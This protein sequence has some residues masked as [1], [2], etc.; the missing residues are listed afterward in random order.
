MQPPVPGAILNRKR[1]MRC[2]EVAL[3]LAFRSKA[4]DRG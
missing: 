3:P 2:V 4:E 1:A